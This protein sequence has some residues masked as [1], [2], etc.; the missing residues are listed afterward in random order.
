VQVDARIAPSIDV[1]LQGVSRMRADGDWAMRISQGFVRWSPDE[2]WVLRAGRIGY[3]IYLLAESRQVGYSYLPLRPS[4]EF[5][6]HIT[7]DDI[8]GGDVSY[9][10]RIGRNLLRARV[11]GGDA[12]GELAFADGSHSN[13]TGYLYGGT[14]DWIRGGWTARIALVD[15]NY[16]AGRDI[17]LLVGALRMTGFPGALA[18]AQDLDEDV[19]ESR[20]V[21]LGVAYDDGPLLAQVLY[22]TVSSDS[23][24][25]PDFDKYYGLV[26][27]RVHK[28]TPFV[29]Y[30]DSRDRGR[31][32][33]AGLP[34]LPL[35]APLNGAVVNIQQATRSTQRAASAGV[36]FD[37][38]AHV[39]FKLQIDR[40]HV[41]DSALVFDRRPS[42]SGSSDM[43]IAAIAMDFVF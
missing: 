5:Y 2:S 28:W 40:A 1:V 6:G 39:D 13:T 26:G 3:D 35:F 20:G 8:D 7:N 19:Y 25:G 24:A 21:Q 14:L 38:S 29:S 30:V 34:E 18:V 42:G 15:F 16:D 41:H 33:D 4:P 12:S 22:G 36:R 11:F 10:H 31:V 43:W 32:H 9:T 37:L 17:P 23:I 27:Y